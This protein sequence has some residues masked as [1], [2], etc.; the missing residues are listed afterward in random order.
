MLILCETIACSYQN[1]FQLEA[2]HV[3]CVDEK[4]FQGQKLSARA[5][6][7]PVE[8]ASLDG[9]SSYLLS[10]SSKLVQSLF[11]V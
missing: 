6:T 10:F 1:T 4:S 9:K 11:I 7:H 5:M 8:G 3:M 2:R